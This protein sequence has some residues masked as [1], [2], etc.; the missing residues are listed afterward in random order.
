MGCR[1]PY[2][3][4]QKQWLGNPWGEEAMLPERGDNQVKAEVACTRWKFTDLLYFLFSSA[5][6][7]NRTA[8]LWPERTDYDYRK[9]QLD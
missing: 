3:Q 5:L 2:L 6:S 8:A 9:E 4:G 1:L 7:N